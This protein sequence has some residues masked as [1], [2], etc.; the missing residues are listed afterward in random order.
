MSERWALALH[1]GAGPLQGSDYS[2]SETHMHGLLEV[3]RDMLAAGAA[4]LDVV[5]HMVAGLE[6]CGLHVAGKGASP[7][8]DGV[9]ELDAA[10]MNGSERRAG[11]V[12]ALG[13]Y[14]SPVKV[15]RRVME[16]TPNIL[17]AGRGASAFARQHKM[18]AV[19][20]PLSYYV[21]VASRTSQAALGAQHGTVGAVALDK[22][23]HLAAATSTGGVLG[24]TP[25]RVGDTPLI[26]AGTWA[27]T[28]V[29]VSCT[30]LGEYFILGNIAA[31]VSARLRYGDESLPAAA[32]GAL[33]DMAKLG[34]EGGMICIDAAG[35]VEMVFDTG[36]MKRGCVTSQ[37]RLEVATFS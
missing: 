23:G 7:N 33:A 8:T 20:D 32:G 24:K 9:W 4:S 37:G 16:A 29:A 18:E 5:E 2:A 28:R 21:P 25:G 17:L 6:S 34:G 1:A 11:A 15:A 35:Q 31:D 10:I 30:G 26:G 19:G 3:G 12:A 14:A 27:D 13:G 22:A 36:G